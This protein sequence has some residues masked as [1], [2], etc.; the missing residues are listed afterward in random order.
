VT[1]ARPK[2]VTSYHAHV[3][4]TDAESRER[5]GALRA[6]IERRFAATRSAITL[7]RWR[8][9]P[10][11][12]HPLPMYQVTFTPE[13][14]AEFVPWLMQ[15]HRGLSVLLHANTGDDLADHTEHT[16]WMGEKL[17]L[18]TEVFEAGN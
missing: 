10:V 16:M 1:P 3:Y 17:D 15:N 18:K 8:D 7:G 2:I 5:A 11:G 6:E 4:Y 12:P 13:L 9:E 14:F